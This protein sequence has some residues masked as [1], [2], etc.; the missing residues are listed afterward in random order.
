MVMRTPDSEVSPTSRRS[1]VFKVGWKSGSSSCSK[2]TVPSELMPT[3]LTRRFCGGLRLAAARG[4]V[5][6]RSSRVRFMRPDARS[7]SQPLAVA[8]SSSSL[9]S[10]VLP[11]PRAPE[12][13]IERPKAPGPVASALRKLS[14][15]VARP[16]QNRGGTPNE[17]RNG[18]CMPE[19][20]FESFEK[21]EKLAAARVP[22]AL[23]TGISS[24][25]HCEE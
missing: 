19:S 17:G 1:S 22:P 12:I 7:A 11:M 18:F 3:R 10:T 16:T 25:L 23:G 14:R 2:P 9:R 8:I 13:T 21:F 20:L 5:V 6:S 24:S 15:M 4:M